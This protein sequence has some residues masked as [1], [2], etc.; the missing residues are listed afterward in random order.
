MHFCYGIGALIS[1]LIAENFLLDKDCSSLVRNITMDH[2]TE[3]SLMSVPVES[4]K[5][6]TDSTVHDEVE[7]IKAHETT[8]VNQAFWIMAGIQVRS[9]RIVHGIHSSVL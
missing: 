6:T 3:T 9:R 8:K 7:L 1:P 4:I 2:T 5:N